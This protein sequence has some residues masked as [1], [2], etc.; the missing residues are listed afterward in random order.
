M[1]Y[2]IPP[3]AHQLHAIEVSKSLK[4]L[5][6]FWEMGTG[7]TACTINIL[8]QKFLE[9]KT[10][11]RTLI[12]APAVVLKNWK[13]EFA[14]HSKIN[15]QDIV[16]LEGSAHK[17]AQLI[18]EAMGKEKILITNYE[19]M[20]NENIVAL[21]LKWDPHI[22][23]C[24]ESHLLKNHS[25]KRAKQVM[26]IADNCQHRYLLTGTPILNSPLDLFMQFRI[27][28]GGATFGQN[29]FGYR[30]TYFEDGNSRWASRPGYFP[31]W[32]P[33]YAKFPELNEKIYTKALRAIKAECLDL[34]P[35]IIKNIEIDLNEK[36]F[37]LYEEM[38]RD[39]ITFVDDKQNDAVF[40][41]NALTKALRLQQIVSGF[42][43]TDKGEE[44]TLCDIP[45]VKVL[46]DLLEELTPAHKVIVWCAFSN[47]Y[48]QVENVCKKL[49][50]EYALLTGEQNA[51]EKEESISSFRH[52]RGNVRVLIANRR[53]GG[54]GINLTEASY[55]IVYSRTFSLGDELQS[56]A[57]NY[58][59]GSERHE[60]I[61]K[62]NLVATS[63]I[64]QICL[65]ALQSK[66]DVSASIIDL[67]TRL[68]KQ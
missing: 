67:A 54:I 8:R 17:R 3:F 36:Q 34:P 9:T 15:P 2:L 57:R 21:I 41:T 33:R 7:K 59:A 62:I 45:R 46:A 13:N 49:K 60:K 16:L 18:E 10:L 68:K 38:K 47:D 44:I 55:S 14:L 1:Q 20:Q 29:F 64:D 27:L 11:R 63:T 51:K 28:D 24:D 31:S 56:E 50:V 61:T 35:L 37:K 66:Q 53:A 22:L 39:F 23:V 40:A 58:R 52:E 25:S 26:K 19:I 5:A 32:Q 6:L 4:D 65:D 48:V 30:A 43:K 12:L 42:V